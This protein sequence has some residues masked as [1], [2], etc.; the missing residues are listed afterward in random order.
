MLSRI[1]PI[2]LV[3]SS[4]DPEY[5]NVVADGEVVGTVAEIYFKKSFIKM[6]KG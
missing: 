6:M 3:I 1:F 5:R 4:V 2:E